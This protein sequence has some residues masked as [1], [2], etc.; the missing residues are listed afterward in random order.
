M[1]LSSSG[2]SGNAVLS[3][4]FFGYYIPGLMIVYSLKN[5]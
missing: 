4:I 5:Y 3:Q 1:S 2:E